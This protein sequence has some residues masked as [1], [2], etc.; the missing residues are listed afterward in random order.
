MGQINPFQNIIPPARILDRPQS[1][2]GSD[3]NP[4]SKQGR[5][6]DQQSE[7]PPQESSPQIPAV[8]SDGLSHLDMK[9]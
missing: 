2:R 6:E 9:A 4:N 7:S 5:N 1:R 8:S 3:G